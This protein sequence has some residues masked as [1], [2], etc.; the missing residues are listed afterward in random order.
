M[1]KLL[2][3]AV[4]IAISTTS[5]SQNGNDFYIYGKKNNGLPG[6]VMIDSVALKVSDSVTRKRLDTLVAHQRDSINIRSMPTFTVSASSDSNTG[7]RKLVV[8]GNSSGAGAVNIQDGGNTIT[9]DGTVNAAQSGTWNI[10]NVSGTVSLPTGAST[11]STLSTLNGKVPSGLTVSSNRLAIYSPDSIRVF[12]TNGFGSS[13]VSLTSTDS[14]NLANAAAFVY[15]WN[16][17]GTSRRGGYIFGMAEATPFTRT[18][19]R[20][21]PLSFDL[22]GN[23]RVTQSAAGKVDLYAPS[24]TADIGNYVEASIDTFGNTRVH[25]SINWWQLE[26]ISS[27]SDAEI[28]ELYGTL[29][30]AQ[31][32]LHGIGDTTRLNYNKLVNI[33]T[34]SYYLAN[35]AQLPLIRDTIGKIYSRIPAGLTVNSNRLA[36]YSPDSIKTWSS[37]G[38]VT[39]DSTTASRKGVVLLQNPT[40]TNDSSTVS[41]KGVVLLTNP[42]IANTTFA[43]TQS[44]TW[45]MSNDSTSMSRKGVVLLSNPTIA[46][47]TFSVTPSGTFSV[48]ATNDSASMSRR[49]V[50]VTNTVTVS[51]TV[52]S[53]SDSTTGSR[54]GVVLLANPTIANTSFAATQ[55]GTWTFSNDSTNT[56]RK[57]VVLLANPTVTNDSTTMGRKGVVVLNTVP[58]SGTVTSSDSTT[59][60]RKGVVLLANP[61]VTNDSTTMSRRFV[62]FTRLKA[63]TD[64][65]AISGS[66]TATSGATAIFDS[67]WS[68]SSLDT[69]GLGALANSATVGWR[70][71]T[72]GIRWRKASDYKIGIKLTMANTAPANDKAVYV[73]L[74]PWFTTD[75]GTTWFSSDQ[76]TTTLP[77]AARGSSTIASPNDLILLG[78]LSYTTQNMTLQRSFTLSQAYG[79]TM[80][81]AFSLV[82]VNYSGAAVGTSNNIISVQPV[83]KVQR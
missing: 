47:T 24:R 27:N 82:I 32:R 21:S 51:G 4:L 42:T 1:K 28:G 26:H 80:P 60:S 7:S 18:D 52:S 83:N 12:A 74:N 17:T 6:R 56:S 10:N 36:I 55:S 31:S 58:I 22:R 44:G 11:E 61:T 50:Q 54:K 13:R 37:G 40:I 64:T 19:G 46:N 70:T 41:R 59:A 48:T 67:T 35:N 73:Y 68:A 49:N 62:A 69:T 15:D 9:V 39:V 66:I 77:T 25:D 2:F 5:F 8:I 34:N 57:G 30:P 71:D 63:S 76:G 45:T 79:Q 38:A 3:L 75:G 20:M 43:A 72:V 65:V 23:L 53:T 78:V 33:E 14:A 16:T 29:I 81:D